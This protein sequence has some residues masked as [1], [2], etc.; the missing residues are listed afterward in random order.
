MTMTTNANQ[1]RI[2]SAQAAMSAHQRVAGCAQP[3]P[4]ETLIDLL[5]DLRH[6]AAASGINFQDAVRISDDHFEAETSELSI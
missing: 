2:A 5:T 3:D 4:Q 1:R 6:W